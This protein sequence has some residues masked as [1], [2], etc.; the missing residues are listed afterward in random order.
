ME[1]IKFA[2]AHLVK[3]GGHKQ[4]AGLSLKPENFAVFYQQLLI[5][6]DANIPEEQGGGVLELEGELAPQELS[7]ETFNL[8]TQFEPFGVD[9]PKPK[10]LVKNAQIVSVRMVGKPGNHMQMQLGFDDNKGV[11]ASEAKQSFSE[12]EIASSDALL[13]MT[14]KKSLIV[15]AIYFNAKDVAKHLKIGDTVD[16]ACELIEDGWNGKREVKLRIIDIREI[17]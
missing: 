5:Y 14:A 12:N 8:I 16:I 3:F 15:S 9:N 13:A 6:A 7:L 4:A 11:I 2:S 17:N 1:A 10:F